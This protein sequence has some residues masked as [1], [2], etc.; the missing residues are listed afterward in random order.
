MKELILKDEAD[1]ICFE[2][3]VLELKALERLCGREVGQ[4]LNYNKTT[5]A[6]LNP[7]YSGGGVLCLRLLQ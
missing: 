4:L 2:Q 7:A 5:T 6:F 3:I 1:F